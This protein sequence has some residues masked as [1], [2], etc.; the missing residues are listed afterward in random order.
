[1]TSEN[2]A[3][4]TL[5]LGLI[6][7]AIQSSR[8]PAM[9][10][11]A[12]RTLGLSVT[13]DLLDLDLIAGGAR[14]L[15]QVLTDV[16]TKGYLGCNITHP[17][18]QAVMEYLDDLSDDA[19][20]LGAVNTVVFRNKKRTGH[21]TDWSGYARN[22]KRG[23]GNVKTGHVLQ[24]G[25]GGAGSAVAY[26]LMKLGVSRLS[27][28]DSSLERARALADKLGSQFGDRISATSD[29]GQAV[30]QADGLVNC[31]PIGMAKYP[32][33]P[34][35]AEMLRADLWVS[36]IV[37]FPLETALLRAAR[38]VG[39]KTLDGG[40]M[41]VFQAAEAFELFTG[42]KPDEEQMLLDFRADFAAKA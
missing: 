14:A 19:R 15:P 34:L 39:C 23:L 9:H 40:G 33:L 12:G 35:P 3:P 20:A 38:A 8:S 28:Y 17:C 4:K 26:A 31:T 29:I 27:L 24:F 37:Y 18:K 13:Y 22:F 2:M 21:N 10:T 1:M 7:E 41:A 30:R 32:G 6:G 11:R 36:E 16:E 25:C 42:I 5:Q